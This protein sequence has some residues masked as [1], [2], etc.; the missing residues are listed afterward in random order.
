MSVLNKAC[1][2]KY[3]IEYSYQLPSSAKKG[4]WS[5]LHSSSRYPAIRSAQVEQLMNQMLLNTISYVRFSFLFGLDQVSTAYVTV[6]ALVDLIECSSSVL[7]Y[8][9]KVHH[10]PVC[11]L[12]AFPLGAVLKV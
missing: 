10:A 6:Y 2:Q 3:R 4:K 5:S 1:D 8:G 12:H 7:V 11:D 9:V